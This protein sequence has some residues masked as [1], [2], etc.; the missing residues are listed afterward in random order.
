MTGLTAERLR[1]TVLSAPVEEVRMSF[2]S[3]RVRR[4][5]LVEVE[6][7]G[8]V[9]IGESWINYPTWGY[10][11]RV[12]TLCDGMAPLV[13][14]QDVSNPADMHRRLTEATLSIGRQW[15]A[16]GPI[17]QAISGVDLALWDL[18]GKVE[19]RPVARLLNPSA[20]RRSV[21]AYASGI[22]PERVAEWCERAISEGF[23]AA[24]VKLGFDEETDRETLRSASEV[25]GA[26]M[27]L[28]ADVNQGWSLEQ[29]RKMAPLLG[30]HNLRWLEEPLAG[31]RLDELEVLA[32]E[33]GIPLATGE[34]LY[35]LATLRQYVTSTAVSTIQ[36]DLTKCGGLTAAAEVAAHAAE[37]RTALAPHCYGSAIGIAASLHLAAAFPGVGPI[38]LDVRDNPLR[39]ELLSEPLHFVGGDLTIPQTPGLGVELDA[40][41]VDR[42]RICHEERTIHDH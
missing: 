32:A 22:G 11:E 39:S 15:G 18:L 4:A 9:G 21:P 36:P 26:D 14:G 2:S 1:V 7:G 30:E 40:A 28:L 34:N 31:D 41:V 8:V 16:P 20:D 19:G 29:A 33:S 37:T 13:L 24:K 42:Y 3:L 38:E 10:R 6:A 17:W 25:L 23:L 12:A 5:C 35:G 27:A